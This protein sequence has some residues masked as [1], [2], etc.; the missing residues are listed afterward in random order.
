M[1]AIWIGKNTNKEVERPL[2]DRFQAV[3]KRSL[4][5]L[6]ACGAPDPSGHSAPHQASRLERQTFSISLIMSRI[7]FAYSLK[8]SL[9]DCFLFY[10]CCSY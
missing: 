9:I 5:L 3:D 1:K 4:S 6:P 7:D 10:L 2:I 8:Q